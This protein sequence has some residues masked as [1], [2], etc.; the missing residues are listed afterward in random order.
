MFFTATP[1]EERGQAYDSDT[2]YCR[3]TL[4]H[5]F[6]YHSWPELSPMEKKVHANKM[7]RGRFAH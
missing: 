1:I 3:S 5:D 6:L 4:I 7:G 2:Q